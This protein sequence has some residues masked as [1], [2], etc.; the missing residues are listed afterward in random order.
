MAGSPLKLHVI[1]VILTGLQLTL[2]YKSQS[3]MAYYRALVT[4]VML[5]QSI[6]S[7]I[8]G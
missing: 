5:D 8:L 1:A 4:T 2:I 7:V 3:F 6:G